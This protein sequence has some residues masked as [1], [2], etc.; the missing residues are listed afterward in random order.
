LC[1]DGQ[2]EA[3][4]LHGPDGEL[5]HNGEASSHRDEDVD[6]PESGVAKSFYKSFLQ[7]VLLLAVVFLLFWPTIETPRPVRFLVEPFAPLTRQLLPPLRGPPLL[8]LR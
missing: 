6:L 3:V 8:N 2:E 5:H 4:A 1:L 7:P